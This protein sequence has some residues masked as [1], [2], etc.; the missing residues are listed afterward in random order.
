[1]MEHT[2]LQS[3]TVYPALH[4]LES[5]GWLL[6]H[7]EDVDTSVAGRP[8]RAPALSADTDRVVRRHGGIG[9]V[10]RRHPSRD[11][12]DESEV[13]VIEYLLARALAKLPEELRARYEAEWRAD[14]AALGTRRL[15]TL[16]W[17]VGLQ[18]VAAELRAQHGLERRTQVPRLAVHAC[19]LGLATTRPTCCDSAPM[20]PARTSWCGRCRSRSSAVW[21]A[22]RSSV[23]ELAG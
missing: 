20:C 11:A 21:C 19:A 14:R 2:G 12:R 16:R 1:M 22:W 10:P 4:R 6:S 5:S 13:R 8:A 17:A 3:G 18:H 23:R 9:A 15:T 7:E